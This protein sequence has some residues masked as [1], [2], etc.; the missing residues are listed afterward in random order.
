MN[1]ASLKLKISTDFTMIAHKCYGI[2]SWL[3]IIVIQN[4]L[5]TI[6]VNFLQIHLLAYG[7]YLLK[8]VRKNFSKSVLI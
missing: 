4:L 7:E 2:M 5:Q 3:E 6:T 8:P 1:I